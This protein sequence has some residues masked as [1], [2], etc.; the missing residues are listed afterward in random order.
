[1][2][3]VLCST[4]A[5]LGRPNGRRFDLL[6]ELAPRIR[7]DGF[8]FMMYDSW[9]DKTDE[10][11]RVLKGLGVLFPV[12][13]FEK[14]IGEFVTKGEFDEAQRRFELNCRIANE[15]GAGRAVL[16]LWNGTLSDS[17]F[18]NSLKGYGILRSIAEK[19]G[20][21]LLVENVVC[22]EKDPITRWQ[23]LVDTYPD[24]GLIYDT[25]MAAF[26]EQDELFCGGGY[27]RL[28]QNVRHLHVNDYGGKYMEWQ[29][30]KTLPVGRGH[31]DFDKFFKKVKSVGYDGYL[32]AE[33]TAFGQNGTVDTKL[34][35][36][37]F[38]KIRGYLDRS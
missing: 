16:H 15:I 19:H 13:H 3:R 7:C 20:I 31:I 37:C 29:A 34:L 12:M 30:L 4:G 2:N 27:Q 10:L 33:A 35:N 22:H 5:L 21:E 17:N 14:H 32:T 25:K 18:E 26:H 8:E 38:N 23:Q 36:D 28:W 1:M 9:Y 11:L 24:A 6:P